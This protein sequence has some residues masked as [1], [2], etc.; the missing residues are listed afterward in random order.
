[1]PLKRR[2]H[3]LD[4][5]REVVDGNAVVADVGSDDVGG[6]SQQRFFGTI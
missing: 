4:E 5:G 3:I 2:M 6:E 1:M